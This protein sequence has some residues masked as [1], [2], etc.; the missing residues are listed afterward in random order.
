MRLRSFTSGAI[1]MV[2]TVEKMNYIEHH[3]KYEVER[4]IYARKRL[5]TT[6]EDDK[7]AF[8]VATAAHMR[9]L[10]VFMRNT[11]GNTNMR[12][13]DYNKEFKVVISKHQENLFARLDKQVFHLDKKRD[14]KPLTH[15]EI[16]E[17][18]AWTCDQLNRFITELEP[19]F[20]RHWKEQVPALPEI[21][22]T[23]PE[24]SAC[25]AWTAVTSMPGASGLS[26]KDGK[27]IY[28]SDSG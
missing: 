12:G 9:S 18:Y 17:L 4:L 7:S 13:Q 21:K 11:D 8:Y 23:K 16:G 24:Y 28:T 14:E 20:Q 1:A 5:E 26:E 10:R 27:I 15:G 19:G 22:S 25:T 6:T 3:L 2:S